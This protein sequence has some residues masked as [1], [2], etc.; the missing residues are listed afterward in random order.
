VFLDGEELGDTPMEPVVLQA[1]R[2]S[3]TLISHK[4]SKIEERIIE[5]KPGQPT[6]LE[7][8]FHKE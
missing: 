6:L 3:V 2:H 1:G 5:V 8:N 7:I 4:L